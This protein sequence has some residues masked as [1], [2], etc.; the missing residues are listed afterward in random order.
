MAKKKS[1]GLNIRPRAKQMS[2]ND[3]LEQIS[4]ELSAIHCAVLT[5]V[6][7]IEGKGS[8]MDAIA[9]TLRRGALRTVDTA[10]SH[11]RILEGRS[12]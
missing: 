11:V 8:V 3:R 12:P 6:A 1:S 4:M 9:G 5:A 7:A 10:R 2:R